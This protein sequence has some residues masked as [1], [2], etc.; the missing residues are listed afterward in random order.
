MLFPSSMRAE[1][2]LFENEYAWP[3]GIIRSVIEFL[4]N[5]RVAVLGVEVWVNDEEHSRVLGG[6]DYEIPFDGEWGEYVDKNASAAIAD[7]ERRDL[8]DS[9]LLN[10]T[11]DRVTRRKAHALALRARQHGVSRVFLYCG[12][13]RCQSCIP[14][15]RAQWAEAFSGGKPTQASIADWDHLGVRRLGPIRNTGMHD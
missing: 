3:P 10:L 5:K 14:V 1:G 9:V 13:Y 4:R 15:F 11:W 8:P 6:S 12:G 7:I 2:V